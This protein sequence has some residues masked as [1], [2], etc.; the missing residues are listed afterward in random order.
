MTS[1]TRIKQKA[2]NSLDEL[3]FDGYLFNEYCLYQNKA[4]DNRF[5]CVIYKVKSGK[6]RVWLKEKAHGIEIHEV[7]TPGQE[8]T[9]FLEGLSYVGDDPHDTLEEKPM[10]TGAERI[11]EKQRNKFSDDG[12]WPEGA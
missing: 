9:P 8:Q 10:E 1:K 6:V 4:T 3:G 5:H 7:L 2:K 11:F 12:N